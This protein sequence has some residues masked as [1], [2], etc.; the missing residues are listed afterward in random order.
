MASHSRHVL[1]RPGEVRAQI[2]FQRTDLLWQHEG[3]LR[4]PYAVEMRAWAKAQDIPADLVVIEVPRLPLVTPSGALVGPT[5]LDML[6]RKVCPLRDLPK[7]MVVRVRA[8]AKAAGLPVPGTVAAW[9]AR[10]PAT[11]WPKPG[12]SRRMAPQREVDEEE[13]E[14]DHPFLAALASGGR[15]A[16][17]QPDGWV[18]VQKT[19]TLLVGEYVYRLAVGMWNGVAAAYGQ[20]ARLAEQAWAE[21]QERAL[22]LWAI[23]QAA[24]EGVMLED[25]QVMALR[26]ISSVSQQVEREI[27]RQAC[28]WLGI[29]PDLD[30][31]R[32]RGRPRVQAGDEGDVISVSIDPDGVVTGRFKK[33]YQGVDEGAVLADL[34]VLKL[35]EVLGA[36]RHDALAFDAD[37]LEAYLDAAA[38]DW[39]E[40]AAAASSSSPDGVDAD[41]PYDVLGVLPQTPMDEVAAAFRGAM[42]AVQH[43]PNAAPQRRLIAAFKAIKTERG[44]S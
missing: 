24:P 20:I 11:L 9:Q 22:S 33:S 8:E 6:T 29:D 2:K 14:S 5:I 12:Q 21:D 15:R 32:P 44:A 18:R 19:S 3:I 34:D 10:D 17:V 40:Q 25:G 38:P 42:Q 39:R 43:L 30:L 27:M 37:L 13:K 35:A 26:P 7:A 16:G 31:K 28:I 1:S 36:L 23:I 41:S 4:S